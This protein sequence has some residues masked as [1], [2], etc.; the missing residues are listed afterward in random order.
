MT[1]RYYDLEHR[2]MAVML[3][4]KSTLL[5]LEHRHGVAFRFHD[6]IITSWNF[7]PTK[8]PYSSAVYQY[9][10]SNPDDDSD[11]R[12]AKLVYFYDRD[13]DD[14]GDAVLT[15]IERARCIHSERLMKRKV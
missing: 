6:Y 9:E 11:G 13:F 8:D 3:P 5:E 12:S 7:H 4:I 1:T 10:D 15:A 14:Q 2:A